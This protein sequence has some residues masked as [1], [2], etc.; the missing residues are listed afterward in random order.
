M[1]LRRALHAKGLRYRVCAHPL[2]DLR[3]KIDIVFRP[4]RVAV[5]VHGCFWHGCPEHHRR[6]SA[7]SQYWH[8]KLARNMN[9]DRQTR[10]QLEQ[11]GWLLIT[12]W[13]HDDVELAAERITDAVRARRP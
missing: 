4:A 11:A 8:D 10:Q 9:R 6:P 12:V 1:A 2:P 7:N 13:E 5:E 3:R